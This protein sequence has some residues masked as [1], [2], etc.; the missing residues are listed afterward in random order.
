MEA[1]NGTTAQDGDVILDHYTN[2]SFQKW[3][4]TPTGNYFYITP[5]HYNSSPQNRLVVEKASSGNNKPVVING[6]NI[7]NNS[8]TQ[9]WQITET[10]CPAT[11]SRGEAPVIVQNNERNENEE[12]NEEEEKEIEVLAD[13]GVQVSPNPGVGFFNIKVTSKDINTLIEYRIL[14]IDGKVLSVQ[15]TRAN[16]TQKINSENWT[17]GIYFVEVVQGGQ[18]KIVKLIKTN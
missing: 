7:P 13:F 8:Q 9:Q 11:A 16:S 5:Q 15:K 12:D 10:G 6:K 2:A 3:K 4:L 18:R 1:D 17:A 14:N